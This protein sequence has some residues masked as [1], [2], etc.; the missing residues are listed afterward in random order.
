MLETKPH[1]VC[2]RLGKQDEGGP[3]LGSR[4]PVLAWGWQVLG[5]AHSQLSGSF[6]LGLGG[7]FSD[8]G[9]CDPPA[10]PNHQPHVTAA[11][12]LLPHRPGISDDEL[13]SSLQVL[14]ANTFAFC[15]TS[16]RLGLVDTRQKWAPSENLR[17]SPGSAGGRWYA[18]V[19][20]RGPGPRIASLGSDGQLCLLD[21]RDL[22]QPVSSVQ[23]PVSTPSPDPELLR[24][25]WAPGL[26]N[27]LAISGT[28]EQDLVSI[29]GS[30]SPRGL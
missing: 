10:R 29:F 14:D 2:Q 7:S 11:V 21:L 26:D 22:S 6:C 12:S 18:E 9:T 13:L 28:A 27:C 30:V 23:C 19:G 25:T 24:V 1:P 20:G 15:C 16:G 8:E 3:G 5:P 17:P 4:A